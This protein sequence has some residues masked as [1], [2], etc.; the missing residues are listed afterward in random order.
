MRVGAS[1]G[2]ACVMMYLDE[3]NPSTGG[4]LHVVGPLVYYLGAVGGL[5]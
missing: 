4:R 3:D 5:K 1:L 2:L